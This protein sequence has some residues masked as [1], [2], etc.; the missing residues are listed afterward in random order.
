MN[1]RRVALLVMLCA[2]LI[3]LIAP[4]V[5]LEH[6]HRFFDIRRPSP[7]MQFA[8]PVLPMSV[9]RYWRVTCF[10]SKSMQAPIEPRR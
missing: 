8:A 6:A 10:V 7:F 9:A 3:L 2:L 1:S 4:V 5:L